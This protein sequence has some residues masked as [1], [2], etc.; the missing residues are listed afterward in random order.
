V[1]TDYLTAS[2]DQNESL[3]NLKR[4]QFKEMY[5]KMFVE[6]ENKYLKDEQTKM[7]K[8]QKAKYENDLDKMSDLTL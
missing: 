5:I 7:S 8:K 3:K 1:V 4:K 2:E 6:S